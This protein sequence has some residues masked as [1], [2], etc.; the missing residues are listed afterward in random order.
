MN[1]SERAL[2]AWAAARALGSRRAAFNIALSLI[3]LNRGEEEVIAAHER[4]IE[5]GS[6]E[7]ASNLAYYLDEQEREPAVVLAAL[8]RAILM[9]SDYAANN[10][11]AYLQERGNTLEEMVSDEIVSELID[12]VRAGNAEAARGLRFYAN[13]LWRPSGVSPAVAHFVRSFAD[14]L[15]ETGHDPDV[16]ISM[17]E[18]AMSMGSSNAVHNK[19]VYL[20]TLGRSEQEVIDA[21]ELAIILGSEPAGLRL[22]TYLQGLGRDPED[23]IGAYHLAS[24]H[25]NF[26]AANNL[27]GYLMEIERTPAEIINAFAVG[28]DMGDATAARNLAWYRQKLTPERRTELAEIFFK[29]G[30]EREA[31]RNARAAL[32]RLTA[33]AFLGH[34]DAA[35]RV[36]RIKLLQ[37]LYDED[38]DDDAL[39]WWR[40]AMERGHVRAAW[41]SRRLYRCRG[42]L[43]EES[44]A[45]ARLL[46]LG[47]K[48]GDEA[49][50]DDDPL[51]P[52]KRQ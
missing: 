13:K 30:R 10:L 12:A 41:E 26:K 33:A 5:L 15:R 40:A 32:I 20:E 35:F 27:A 4:A 2:A 24:D 51:P 23:V 52:P 29:A 47:Y 36:G 25:G 31:E 7:A 14:I 46:E 21:Y 3:R 34:A 22:P 50:W 18:L 16:V 49:A 38:F 6:V 39:G 17:Y 19:A 44:A 1:T 42:D 28:I 11:V 9:G 8:K 37:A 48:P 45:H 43:V